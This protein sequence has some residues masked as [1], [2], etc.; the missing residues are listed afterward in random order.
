MGAGFEEGRRLTGCWTIGSEKRDMGS[1]C[2]GLQ[3]ICYVAV[4]PGD[5]GEYTEQTGRRP[6]L[7]PPGSSCGSGGGGCNAGLL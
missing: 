7:R 1:R 5:S 3:V 2:R 4:D 6:S